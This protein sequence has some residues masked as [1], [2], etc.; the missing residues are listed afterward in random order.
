M[1][2]PVKHDLK[3]FINTANFQAFPRSHISVNK[4]FSISNL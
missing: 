4:L 3:G 2:T 1:K